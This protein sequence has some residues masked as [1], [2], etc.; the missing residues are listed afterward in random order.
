MGWVAGR[1]ARTRHGKP[2]RPHPLPTE[3]VSKVL[4]HGLPLH[5][6]SKIAPKNVWI[7]HCAFE[8]CSRQRGEL[9]SKFR[10]ATSETISTGEG[11][12]WKIGRASCRERV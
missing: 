3:T 9:H 12:L 7:V 2:R 11:R 8:W 6:L 10:K 1:E 4:A 5:L